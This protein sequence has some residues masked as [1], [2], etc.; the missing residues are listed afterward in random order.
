LLYEFS[1]IVDKKYGNVWDDEYEYNE[2]VSIDEEEN[3]QN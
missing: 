3:K 2:E 1:E